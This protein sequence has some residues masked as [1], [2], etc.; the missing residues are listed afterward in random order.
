MLTSYADVVDAAL[1]CRDHVVHTP[2]VRS[3]RLSEEFNAEVLLKLETEQLTGSFKVRGALSALVQSET[4]E[5]VVTASAGNHGLGLAEAAR[6]LNRRARVFVSS[7]ADPMKL[8]ML[9]AHLHADVVEVE[10]TYDEAERVAQQQ[11]R[12]VGERFISSYNDRWVVAGQG[13][14]AYEI[15]AERDDVDAIVTPVGCGGLISGLGLVARSRGGIQVIGVEPETSPAVSRSVAAGHVVRIADDGGRSVAE[16]LVGN[17]DADSITV[18]LAQRVVDEFRLASE[19][20]LVAA[21]G[22]LLEG[23]RIV[24]E[25]SAAAAVLGI[26]TA[27]RR[28]AMTIAC[29]LSGA[30]VSGQRLQ[31]LI[32]GRTDGG[33]REHP[34]AEGGGAASTRP[35]A[36]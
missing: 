8:K 21:V 23:E 6:R 34:M 31:R 29:I 12:R 10:G 4:A 24:A 28:G 22:R 3:S 2:L 13:T 30:N 16:A 32:S 1:L 27:V 19:E 15:L 26:E 33:D 18:P 25:P 36:Q 5:V 7:E 20:E 9:H 35:S 14:V 17:L 11:A